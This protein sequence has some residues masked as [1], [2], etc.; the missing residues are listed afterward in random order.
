M[1]LGGRIRNPV[2]VAE[3]KDSGI[4]GDRDHVSIGLLV[5]VAG[6]KGTPGDE[7]TETAQSA[8]SQ[9][10]SP[11]PR[12]FLLFAA[13]Q[14]LRG[15]EPLVE[16]Y[17][18]SYS[19]CGV[20]FASIPNFASFYSEDINN[21]VECI[22]LLNEIIFDFDQGSLRARCPESSSA[23]CTKINALMGENEMKRY[24]PILSHN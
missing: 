3:P 7:R 13:G 17:A 20:L 12:R 18:Q 5:E 24:Y 1:T 4:C 6:S 10:H 21:G 2:N 22:R 8:T 15:K 16:L 19:C 11:R 14:E 23:Y 9:E